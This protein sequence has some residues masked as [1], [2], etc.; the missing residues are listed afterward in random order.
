MFLLNLYYVLCTAGHRL[1]SHRSV[2]QVS[3]ECISDQ[4]HKDASGSGC[5]CPKIVPHPQQVRNYKS[6]ILL[7]Y[8]VYPVSKV[9]SDV[10]RI[11][12]RVALI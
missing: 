8:M 12:E 1:F 5:K 9:S 7:G 10:R 2:H 3:S 6:K 11:F 4:F